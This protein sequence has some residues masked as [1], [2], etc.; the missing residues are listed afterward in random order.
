ME[1]TFKRDEDGV[2][3]TSALRNDGV[4]LQVPTYDRVSRLPHDMAHCLVERELGLRRG[5]WGSVAE[6]ALFPGILVV[7]GRQPVHAT[8]R[9]QA[10]LSEMGQ[11][12]TEA[13][14]FVSLFVEIMEKGTD[15]HEA[16]LRKALSAMWRPSKPSRALPNTE[17]ARRVCAALRNA[18]QQWQALKP[19]ESLTVTW[20][21]AKHSKR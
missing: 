8:A 6:G 15:A 9:S 2:C 18:Q 14:V 12:G 4:L 1:I 13:E 16:A 17:E 11:Q 19:G 20:P 21:Y 5:F 3:V 10:I 7:S